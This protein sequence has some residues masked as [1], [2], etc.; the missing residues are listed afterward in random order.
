MGQ[1]FRWLYKGVWYIEGVKLSV[2][3]DYAA[4]AVLDLAAY[5]IDGPVRK[6]EDLALASGTSANFLVQILIDLKSA[7]I[8][9]SARGKR[10]GYRLA[11]IPEEITLGDVWRAVDGQVL[12]TPALGDEQCPK[13]LRM[14]WASLRDSV[15]READEITFAQLLDATGHDKE[16]YYI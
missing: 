13:V 7:E 2:K 1:E 8:V 5:P 15:N 6:V 14:A 16:M 9:R 4:R 11:R 3:T 10:G 12:D